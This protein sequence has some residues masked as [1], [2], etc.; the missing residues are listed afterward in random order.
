[1]TKP[2]ITIKDFTVT[3]NNGSS[4]IVSDIDLEVFP[5]EILGIIGPSGAGKTT[6]LKA[7]A[8]L[9]SP[10]LISGNYIFY[11]TSV[12]PFHSLSKL[13]EIRS[14][15]VFIHQ[16]PILFNGSVRYNLQYG[17]KIRKMTKNYDILESLIESFNIKPLL[18]RHVNSLSGGEKQRVC[19]A[20]AMALQPKVLVLDEPTQNL[21][22]QN[23][24]NIEENIKKFLEDDNRAVIIATHNFFQTKRI[25]NRTAILI[26]GRIVEV[27]ETEKMF[28]SPKSQIAADFLNGKLVF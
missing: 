22:P 18:S 5:H 19:L 1:M 28:S 16:E 6:L 20:R 2:L 13:K 17:L 24:A 15:I 10:E 4:R 21:D 25:T 8:L 11:G 23:V 26:N 12:L 14:N 27:E 3:L 7:I 9:F